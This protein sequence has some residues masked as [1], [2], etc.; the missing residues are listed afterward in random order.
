MLAVPQV[1]KQSEITNLLSHGVVECGAG[2]F[3]ST[4][5]G[6]SSGGGSG[7]GGPKRMRL[8]PL[9]DSGMGKLP[10]DV[11]GFLRRKRAML[12]VATGACVAR[13]AAACAAW[14]RLCGMSAG[15]H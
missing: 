13:V 3:S 6:G 1:Y 4:A 10:R 7:G 5:S 15:C 9:L 12:P 11:T 14:L 2:S 8:A